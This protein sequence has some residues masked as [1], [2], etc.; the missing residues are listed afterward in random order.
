[1][2]EEDIEGVFCFKNASSSQQHYDIRLIRVT[3]TVIKVAAA[4]REREREREILLA[5]LLGTSHSAA[6]AAAAT[7]GKLINTHHHVACVKYTTTYDG[8][9]IAGR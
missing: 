6:A 9:I 3:I 7:V 5:I 8:E 1:M 2:L 4:T